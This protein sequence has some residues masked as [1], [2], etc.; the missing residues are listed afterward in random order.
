M[1]LS[2][3]RIDPLDLS[4]SASI[5]G[6]A[7]GCNF[8][9]G[10]GKRRCC[11]RDASD[12]PKSGSSIKALLCHSA[13]EAVNGSREGSDRQMASDSVRSRRLSHA[14]VAD[15]S[16]VELKNN[17]SLLSLSLSLPAMAL[18]WKKLRERDGRQTVETSRMLSHM[19]SYCASEL[20]TALRLGN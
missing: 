4:A 6:A 20:T 3:L 9:E 15:Q 13:V 5:C 17:R 11:W 10:P 18:R 2:Q 12:C 1:L 14:K 7:K 16:V 19:V 8:V